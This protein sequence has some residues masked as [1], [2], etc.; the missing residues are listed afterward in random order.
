MSETSGGTLDTQGGISNQLATLVPS[1]DPSKDD[2]QVYQQKVQLV[3]SVW[4][5]HRI[6]ELITRLILNTTGSA[7]AKLQI[8]HEELNNNE[9]KSV[10][11]L[12]EYLGGQWGKTALE[13]RYADAER[14]LF[15]CNQQ[16][17]ESHDSYLARADV[18]W[19]KLKSQK[20]QMNDLQ[21][22][23]TLRGAQLSSEDKK[24]II[25]DSDSSLEGTL[26]ISRVQEA[27]RL[28]G[29]SFFHEMTGLGKKQSKAK[30]YDAANLSVDDHLDHVEQDDQAHLANHEDWTWT[31]DDALETLLAEGDEDAVF[32]TDFESAA[33]ELLQSDDDL[34][35]AY[36]TYIEARKKLNEKFRSRGFWPVGKGK[37]RFGGKA[38]GKGKTTWSSR[39]T[40]Q[41]RILESNCRLCGKRGHWRNECPNRSQGTTSAPSTAAVTLS[42][43]THVNAAESDMPEE[44]LILPEVPASVTKDIL[45]EF[46]FV[47]S[48]FYSA[49]EPEHPKPPESN[50][51]R[52]LRDKIRSHISGKYASNFGVKTLVNRIEAKIRQQASLP[53]SSASPAKRI[54]RPDAVRGSKMPVP[55]SD[56]PCCSHATAQ[57]IDTPVQSPVQ[58]A[59]QSPTDVLFSTHD[60]WGILDTGA[61]KTV[62]GSDHVKE[63]LEGLSP[64]IK[65]QVKRSSCDVIFRFG[66]QGTLRAS[67]ALIL[68]VGGM[69][70]K[71]AVV[72]GGTP[73]L[74]SNTLLRALGALID[75][76]HHQL[77]IPKFQ[78]KISLQLSPKGLYLINMNDLTALAPVPENAVSAAETYA[79]DC[80]EGVQ[81]SVSDEPNMSHQ[82]VSSEVTVGERPCNQG[83]SNKSGRHEVSIV[84]K[85]D[86]I[87]HPDPVINSPATTTEMPSQFCDQDIRAQSHPSSERVNH[88]KLDQS[89][90]ESPGQCGRAALDRGGIHQPP[91]ADDAQGRASDLRESPF[92]QISR[93]GLGHQSNLDQVEAEA[94]TPQPAPKALAKALGARPKSNAAPSLAATV[95]V[96][97]EMDAFEMMSEGPWVTATENRE[98]IQAL[99][100]R[101]LSLEDAM[102]RMLMMMQDAMPTSHP[103]PSD[104]PETAAAEW[105][106]PWNN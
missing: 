78:A 89:P 85:S 55:V 17:D 67:H 15:Q 91:H 43:A 97:P 50:N 65:K 11:K 100:A 5:K 46:S 28:L 20:L 69:W 84:Q 58:T 60:T 12:I 73:F 27:V 8:H 96:E 37:S 106:D 3:L 59:S 38:K 22:Y 36:T 26:T 76:Q 102:R 40:L 77:I 34:A 79:Q 93:R 90:L 49:G 72:K 98:D 51:M 52:V 31:E 24:R 7:F 61:T 25:L 70:L 64:N 105:D 30:V 68:P 35:H 62:M 33:S 1:F 83:D 94:E 87:Q 23:I 41:Q 10:Q 81:K 2:L 47:Q 104:H 54:L 99:Q 88:V 63:F 53:R 18:L 92:G 103:M 82:V 45:S 6:S 48:V 21:A 29:T 71:I 19:S 101:M 44:F 32:I 80:L 57:S 9:E 95:P 75:T 14:A 39:K 4:P 16:P 86:D 13:K 74:V 42:M 66:N 56:L